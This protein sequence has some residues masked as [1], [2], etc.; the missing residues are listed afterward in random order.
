[1]SGDRKEIFEYIRDNLR[2]VLQD[3]SE[4]MSCGGEVDGCLILTDP[5]GQDHVISENETTI[6]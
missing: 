4:G 2:V 5:T 3:A 6:G 1:M